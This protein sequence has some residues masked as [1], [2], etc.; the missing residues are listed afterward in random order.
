M[1]K[2]ALYG[3]IDQILTPKELDTFIC[4]YLIDDLHVCEEIK[5]QLSSTFER[6]LTNKLLTESGH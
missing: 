5:I 4:K 1:Q 3:M 2:F 6:L